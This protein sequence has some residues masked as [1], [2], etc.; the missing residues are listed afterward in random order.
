MSISISAS[1]SGRWMMMLSGEWLGP[2]QARSM[3]SPPIS[4]V[5]RSWN[6]SSFGGLAGSSSRSSSRRV[7]SCPMRV[8]FLSNSEAAPTWSA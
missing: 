6:V 2:C 3:R 1:W 5:R 8:A 7:S 4:S